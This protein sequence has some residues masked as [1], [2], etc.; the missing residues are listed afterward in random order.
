MSAST[1]KRCPLTGGCK[2]RVLVE[3]S[4]GPQSGVRFGESV[5]LWE[6][7]ASGGSTVNNKVYNDYCLMMTMKIFTKKPSSL[8][9]FSLGS[10]KLLKPLDMPAFPEIHYQIIFNTQR[11]SELSSCQDNQ[12]IDPCT[13]DDYAEHEVQMLHSKTET[14]LNQLMTMSLMPNQTILTLRQNN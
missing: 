5:H 8:R 3:K 11:G 10:F 13:K 4:P 9:L 12:E 6:V 7:S 1:Y 2:Y 14:T